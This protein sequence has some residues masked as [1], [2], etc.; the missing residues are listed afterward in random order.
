M[1]LKGKTENVFC[2]EKE[3]RQFNGM[4][5]FKNISLPLWACKGI[6]FTYNVVEYISEV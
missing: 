1:L 5:F 4:N 2:E 3:S 6:F